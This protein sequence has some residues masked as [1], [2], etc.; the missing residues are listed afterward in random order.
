MLENA[1]KQSE[2]NIIKT[3]ENFHFVIEN[4]KKTKFRIRLNK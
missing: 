1:E 3:N 4:R 2:Q